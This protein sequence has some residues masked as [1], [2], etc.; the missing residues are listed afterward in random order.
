MPLSSRPTYPC[1]FQRKSRLLVSSKSRSP[2]FEPLFL[3]WHCTSLAA[4]CNNI[5]SSEAVCPTDAQQSGLTVFLCFGCLIFLSKLLCS[6]HSATC[7]LARQLDYN[8][9]GQS[10]VPR[11]FTTE[12]PKGRQ[13][14][15]VQVRKHNDTKNVEGG[16][17]PSNRK[18]R[19]MAH[20]TARVV[21]DVMELCG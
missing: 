18:A 19:S 6:V 17:K 5:L 8:I 13:S 10:C 2:S 1:L 7:G 21:G 16:E 4:L 14:A 11:I 9:R 12:R 15:S 3:K 20:R